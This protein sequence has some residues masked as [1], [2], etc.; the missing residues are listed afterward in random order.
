MY[1]VDQKSQDG[2]Y[3]CLKITENYVII[4]PYRDVA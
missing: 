1:I 4:K 3:I 2:I